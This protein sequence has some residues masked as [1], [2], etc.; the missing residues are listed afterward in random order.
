MPMATAAHN[1]STPLSR[2]G[3]SSSILRYG[4]HVEG[5]R[6][7][8]PSPDDGV[9]WHD[10]SFSRASIA[11]QELP[12]PRGLVVTGPRRVV[13]HGWA[14]GLRWVLQHFTKWLAELSAYGE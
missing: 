4:R 2:S 9:G 1:P 8:A 5:P 12:L 3:C 10:V 13:V 11:A 7:M 14:V 6:H